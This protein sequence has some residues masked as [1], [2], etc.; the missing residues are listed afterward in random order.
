M[1]FSSQKTFTRDE[2]RKYDGRSGV[3][4]IAFRNKVYDVSRSFQWRKGIH[5]VI[6]RAGCDL[7]EELKQAPHGSDILKKFPVVGELLNLK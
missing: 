2:L 6:H 4:Y 5:Q 3:S 7:T 1:D